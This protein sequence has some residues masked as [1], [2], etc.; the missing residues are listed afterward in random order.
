MVDKLKNK[1]SSME[2]R[3][4]EQDIE[5]ANLRGY[6]AG[7]KDGY[8]IAKA[9]VIEILQTLPEINPDIESITNF[10]TQLTGVITKIKKLEPKK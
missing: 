5:I 2:L 3:I 9:D 7:A 4:I 1:L 6:L 10:L 8:V